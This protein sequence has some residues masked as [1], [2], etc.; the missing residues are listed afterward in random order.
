LGGG[1]AEFAGI[2]FTCPNMTNL[3]GKI[4]ECHR[5]DARA[6]AKNFPGEGQRKKDRK[7]A[8]KT[9]NS[10]TG[11]KPVS[12]ISVPCMKIQGGCGPPASAAYAMRRCS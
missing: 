4:Y 11:I 3:V 6:P 12:T 10:T 5:A 1:G 7:I 2:F 8:N 9:E